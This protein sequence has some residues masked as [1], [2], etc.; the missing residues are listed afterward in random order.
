MITRLFLSVMGT[1]AVLIMIGYAAAV[2]Q[3]PVDPF[4]RAECLLKAVTK[5]QKSQ[6]GRVAHRDEGRFQISK[7]AFGNLGAAIIGLPQQKSGSDKEDVE[8]N[9]KPISDLIR[10]VFW[11]YWTAA[12]IGLVS[13]IVAGKWGS[14]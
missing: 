7:G 2:Y 3:Q 12:L 6:C 1:L 4:T 11:S 10:R 13:G 9:Q 5:Y 8:P 14:R